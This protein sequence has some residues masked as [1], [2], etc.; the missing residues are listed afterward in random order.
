MKEYRLQRIEIEE[1][2]RDREI[3]ALALLGLLYSD[4]DLLKY[5]TY[6]MYYRRTIAILM[7]QR[8]FEGG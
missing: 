2:A 7:I 4:Y 8:T 1:I 6:S 3:L 5:A